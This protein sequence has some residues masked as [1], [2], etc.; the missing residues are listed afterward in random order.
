MTIFRVKTMIDNVSDT[1]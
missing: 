1:L